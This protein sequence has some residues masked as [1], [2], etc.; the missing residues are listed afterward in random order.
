MVW[1]PLGMVSVV[2]VMEDQVRGMT[3][4]KVVPHALMKLFSMQQWVLDELWSIR[5]ALTL[6]INNRYTNIV[7]MWKSIHVISAVLR[8]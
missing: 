6:N 2:I 4:H 7:T 5:R 3:R 1:Q 8:G